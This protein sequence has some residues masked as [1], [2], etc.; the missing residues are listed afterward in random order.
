MDL[1]IKFGT[2]TMRGLSFC[3]ANFANLLYYL[4]PFFERIPVKFMSLQIENMVTLVSR[5]G[6]ELQRYEKGSRL[7]VGYVIVL[8]I[9]FL[10][11]CLFC[12]RVDFFFFP[13]EDKYLEQFF[14]FLFLNLPFFF[15]SFFLIWVWKFCANR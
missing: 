10:I 4:F 2:A 15:F 7:V 1:R 3:L 11:L 9:I 14:V 5:T 8:L 6:R 13:F 12:F